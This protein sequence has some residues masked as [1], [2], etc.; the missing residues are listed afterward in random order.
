MN[1]KII[2]AMKG[3][4]Y[5]S[6]MAFSYYYG[7]LRFVLPSDGMNNAGKS[8]STSVNNHLDY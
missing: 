2:R 4:D 5:G 6:G 3:V 7:Y 1:D 8:S